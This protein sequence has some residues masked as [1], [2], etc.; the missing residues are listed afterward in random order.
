MVVDGFF[1]L[2]AASDTAR[3]GRAGI[4]EFGLPYAQDAAITRHLASFL[5]QHPGELPD[6]LLLNGGVF[7]ADA[8]ARRLAGHLER[9][10]RRPGYPAAQR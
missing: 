5:Q 6:T 3:K 9:L 2:V 4:V 7:R 8:L 10:A 1:P